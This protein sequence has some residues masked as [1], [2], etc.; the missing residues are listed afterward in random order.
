MLILC[1]V[2]AMIAAMEVT[3]FTKECRN[4]Y[5]VNAERSLKHSTPTKKS[6]DK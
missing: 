5:K 3:D 2:V 1:L 6:A 4:A